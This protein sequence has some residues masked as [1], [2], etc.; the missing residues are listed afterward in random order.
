MAAGHSEDRVNPAIVERPHAANGEPSVASSIERLVVASE[1]VIT[2]RIDLAIL[3]AQELV[4]RTVLAA[5]FGGCGVIMASAAW[6]G[7]VAAIVLG[8]APDFG[9]AA[10]VAFFAAINAAGAGLLISLAVRRDTSPQRIPNPSAPLRE[11]QPSR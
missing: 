2:K 1:G 7:L 3:E 9:L 5:V 6:F 10:Q 4:S 8:A 11:G